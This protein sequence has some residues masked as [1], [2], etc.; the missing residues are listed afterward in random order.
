MFST[1]KFRII[2]R[3]GGTFQYYAQ[4]KVFDLFWMDCRDFEG[5]SEMRIN[6]FDNN[7]WVVEKYIEL[8][9]EEYR[10]KKIEQHRSI[11]KKDEVIATY[12]N[13]EKTE[14]V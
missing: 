7:L 9:L 6:T 12:Y 2:K 11:A 13:G 8:K 10:P 4:R 3:D 1:P 14:D 5:D